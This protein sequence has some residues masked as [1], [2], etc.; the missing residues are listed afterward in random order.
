MRVTELITP[1]RAKEILRTGSPSGAVSKAKVEAF[2]TKMEAGRWREEGEFI[3]IRNGKLMNGH[4]RLEA[5]IRSGM[6]IKFRIQ[7]DS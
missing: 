5:V 1:E 4:H 6:S 3:Y 7:Y 2:K